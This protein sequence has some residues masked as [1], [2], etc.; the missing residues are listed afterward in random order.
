MNW[1]VFCTISVC[2]WRQLTHKPEH[3]GTIQI[4]WNMNWFVLFF[5]L[6]QYLFEGNSLINLNIKEPNK[7][8][9]ELIC[10]LYDFSIYLKATY[11]C[12]QRT[13]IKREMLLSS[14]EFSMFLKATHSWNQTKPTKRELKHKV[15]KVTSTLIN[16]KP[17]NGMN[18]KTN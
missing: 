17:Y 6:F 16:R 8:I 4:H 18:H 12:N 3:K 11:S 1:F 5:L 14:H 2:V 7:S 10:F 13:P 9:Y 15:M